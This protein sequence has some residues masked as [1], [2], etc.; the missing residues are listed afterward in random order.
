MSSLLHF[1]EMEKLSLVDFPTGDRLATTHNCQYWALTH[2]AVHHHYCTPPQEKHPVL[3]GVWRTSM[4]TVRRSRI[5]T[6]V[7]VDR[8]L[9]VIAV[10][11]R[12]RGVSADTV[13]DLSTRGVTADSILMPSLSLPKV[14]QLL[15]NILESSGGDQL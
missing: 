4:H 7:T 9:G 13:L 5:R 10:S 2:T 14:R 12:S 6:V 3:R 8:L 15:Q 1:C 11:L